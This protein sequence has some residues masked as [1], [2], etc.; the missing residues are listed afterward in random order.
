MRALPSNTPQAIIVFMAGEHR[1]AI[2]RVDDI[3]DTVHLNS[4]CYVVQVCARHPNTLQ[5]ID[6]IPGRH[7]CTFSWETRIWRPVTTRVQYSRSSMHEPICD[8]ARVER[9]L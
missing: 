5:C 3:I 2:S 1:D 6:D 9:S 7:I 4:I 8:T